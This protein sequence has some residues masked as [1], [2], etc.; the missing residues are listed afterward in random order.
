MFKD[1]ILSKG[2]ALHAFLIIIV[3]T[4]ITRQFR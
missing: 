3:A 4:A 1:M 2:S